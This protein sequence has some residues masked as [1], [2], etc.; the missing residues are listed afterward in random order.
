MKRGQVRTQTWLYWL[1]RGKCHLCV[2]NS[3]PRQ[4]ERPAQCP[5]CSYWCCRWTGHTPAAQEPCPCHNN[6]ERVTRFCSLTL[7]LHPLKV[8]HFLFC[9]NIHCYI[10][11]FH[12]ASESKTHHTKPC[13]SERQ[14]YSD[15]SDD[16]L[17]WLV[18][19]LHCVG[20][21]YYI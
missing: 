2:A 4:R 11:S 21:H 12:P 17:L 3:D 13:L 6:T 8:K 15:W 10:S 5:W 18:D 7:D 9:H 1:P 19:H 20:N 16:W 14:L